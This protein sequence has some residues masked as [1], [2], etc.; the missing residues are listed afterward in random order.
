MSF[1]S[2]VNCGFYPNVITLRSGLY[3]RK[4]VCLSSLCL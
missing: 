4:S 1:F 3:Y 2:K